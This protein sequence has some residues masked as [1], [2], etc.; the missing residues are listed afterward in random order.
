MKEVRDLKDL[1]IHDVQPGMRFG[2]VIFVLF[3]EQQVDELVPQHRKSTYG[4]SDDETSLMVKCSVKWRR[5]F[6]VGRHPGKG[7]GVRFRAKKE[8]LKRS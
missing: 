8:P 7:F 2:V 1:T 6:E 4:S 3:H 5:R